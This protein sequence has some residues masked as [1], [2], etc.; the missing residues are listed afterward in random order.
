MALLFLDA[1]RV[2]KEA[3]FDENSFLSDAD[4]LHHV[5]GAEAEVISSVGS[6]YA[7]SIFTDAGFANSTA[8]NFLIDLGTNLAASR[9][10]YSQY[11][12]QDIAMADESGKRIG[13]LRAELR[14]I[15]SGNIRLF[16]ASLE[17]FGLK[18]A[19]HIGI[20]GNPTDS[21]D[22]MFTKA[23]VF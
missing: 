19:S 17:E 15:Q 14:K 22:R 4:I 1:A 13:M 18:E 6:R 7:M 2:R 5:N 12:G 9:L 20:S 8:K 16:S 3:G 10:L 23:Q 21:T 11:K